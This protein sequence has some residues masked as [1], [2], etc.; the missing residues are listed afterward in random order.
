ML[1]KGNSFVQTP[2]E[3]KKINLLNDTPK[4]QSTPKNWKPF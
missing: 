1:Q 4:S 3:V 2:E